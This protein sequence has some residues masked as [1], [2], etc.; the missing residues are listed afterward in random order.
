MQQLV[1]DVFPDGDAWRFMHGD[2]MS[3]SYLSR[4]AALHAAETY[5]LQAGR[6]AHIRVFS[7]GG[8]V[9]EE[10]VFIRASDQCL[11]DETDPIFPLKR[12]PSNDP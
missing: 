8:R 6:T 10:R 2:T 4:S 11:N 12:S 5:A 7:L 3:F 1:Y 9:D